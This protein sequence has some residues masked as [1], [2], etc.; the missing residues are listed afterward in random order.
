MILDAL[1]DPDPF[2]GVFPT[3]DDARQVWFEIRDRDFEGILFKHKIMAEFY[4]D[5]YAQAMWE[6]AGK[7]DGTEASD[8]LFWA[9]EGLGI[10][11]NLL[12]EP[13]DWLQM[14]NDWIDVKEKVN[15]ACE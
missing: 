2:K 12:L 10:D 4:A 9:Y 15:I 11:P 1:P 3:F 8:F 13:A 6:M 7:P 14:Q 5:E